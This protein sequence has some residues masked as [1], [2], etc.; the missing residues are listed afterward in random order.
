MTES[1]LPTI[2]S[3]LRDWHRR[4]R[5]SQWAHYE[6]ERRLLRGHYLIGLPLIVLSAFTGTSIFA[7]IATNPSR[8]FKTIVG[9]TALAGAILGAL[10]TFLRSSDRAGAHRSAA[11]DYSDL[12]RRL[13]VLL[14]TDTNPNNEAV[15]QVRSRL[16]E[17]AARSPAIDP[18]VW[19]ATER[20]LLIR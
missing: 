3:V 1:E 15:E 12:R 19:R 10:Q 7:S 20:K 17:L 16:G 9:F 18:R 14:A 4:A 8:A 6:A 5:E 11:T 13:E 2:E